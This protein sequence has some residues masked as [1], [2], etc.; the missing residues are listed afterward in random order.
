MSPWQFLDAWTS[1]ELCDL[2]DARRRNLSRRGLASQLN[3]N[4]RRR[5]EYIWLRPS[6]VNSLLAEG[7]VEIRRQIW[8]PSRLRLSFCYLGP[9]GAVRWVAENCKR[10]AGSRLYVYAGSKEYANAPKDWECCTATHMP[11]GARRLWVL[12][13]HTDRNVEP[14]YWHLWLRRY[15]K[16]DVEG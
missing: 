8:P 1:D 15:A 10:V 16:T 9:Q 5:Q 12:V 13:Q 7:V 6:E 2:M 14:G 4:G 11:V 3:V